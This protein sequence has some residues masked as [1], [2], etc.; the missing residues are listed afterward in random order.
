MIKKYGCVLLAVLYFNMWA[1]D[2]P[3][4]LEIGIDSIST[5]SSC[6]SS[7]SESDSDDSSQ[8]T[9]L[10]KMEYQLVPDE[11]FISGRFDNKNDADRAI[12]YKKKRKKFYQ[13]PIELFG[14]Q[15]YARKKLFS[16]SH[17]EKPPQDG[18]LTTQT[19][20]E[21][22]ENYY[23]IIEAQQKQTGVLFSLLNKSYQSIKHLEAII[24][25][26]KQSK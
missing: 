2:K 1:A 22:L 13:D 6:Y 10:K 7:Q 18:M 17:I 26:S 20:L 14:F 25:Q 24:A 15:I 23:K 5:T 3:Q 16:V 8:E 11:I 12:M 9:A 19:L 4:D 21:L